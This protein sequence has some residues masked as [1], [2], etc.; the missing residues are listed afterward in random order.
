MPTKA[1]SGKKA[2]QCGLLLAGALF[3]TATVAQ[4][5]TP[6]E[7]FVNG[8]PMELEKKTRE[9]SYG[10]LF[11]G[12]DISA[13]FSSRV[14]E[15]MNTAVLPSRQPVMPLG[16][17]PMPEVG[18]VEAETV[19]HGKMS[20]DRFMAHADSYMQGYLVIHKGDIVYEKYPRMRAEDAHLWMSCAKPTASLV[21]D[22]LISEGRIDEDLPITKYITDWKGTDWDRVSTRDVLDMVSGMDL[23]DTAES[24]FDPDNIAT[25]V[26]QAE[27]AFPHP[28]T[29]EVE[30]LTDVLKSTKASGKPGEAFEYSSALTQVLVV[31]A[32]AVEGER[33]HQLFDRRVWSKIGA[34]GPL[35]LHLTPDGIAAAHG[36][37]S[38]NLRDMARFG[39][40]Y[41][42]SWNKIA[43]EQV[44]SDEI[45][46]R[47]QE[48]IR[49]REVFMNGAGTRFTQYLNTDDAVGHS[50][51]WDLV[52][53]DGDFWKGGLM[54]Q[55][56]YVSPARDLVIVYFSLNNDDY[57][58]HRFVRPIATS[59]LFD[60]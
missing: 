55:G 53:G 46:K 12:G 4:D 51:Q 60:K 41:T 16:Q 33:W 5:R 26:Y 3:T 42:P 15:F 58:S 7:E 25:R 34:E 40:L 47:T 21:I 17:R 44:V 32:E 22:Q 14:A 57:S 27:F 9:T 43:V 30:L 10:E 38:S 24:R 13:Y 11:R 2:Y 35:Q 23:N 54:G 36:L 8:F 20:L 50:R 28:K 45:L 39:M 59:G 18:K 1:L 48:G 49:A 56:L 29:G 37:V 52:W 6:L 19:N 31:L